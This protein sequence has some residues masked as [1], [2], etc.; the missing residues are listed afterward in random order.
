MDEDRGLGDPAEFADPSY[1]VHMGVGDQ[2]VDY[3]QTAPGNLLYDAEGFRP[4]IDHQPFPASGMAQDVAIG[5]K[6]PHRYFSQ[7]KGLIRLS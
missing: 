7:H 6:G 3:F 5:L 1:V 2:D 4:G